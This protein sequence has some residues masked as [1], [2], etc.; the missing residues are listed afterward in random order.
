MRT[1]Y[2]K[3]LAMTL[4]LA[5]ALLC[6]LS[7]CD[8][9]EEDKT[10]TPVYYQKTFRN[11][12]DVEYNALDYIKVPIFSELKINKIEIDRKVEY[13]MANVV[14]SGAEYETFEEDGSA[15]VKLFDTANIT[16]AGKAKDESLDISDETMAGMDNSSNKEGSDLIIGSGSFIGEYFGDESKHNEGFEEQLIGMKV[17]ETKDI[18]VTFP[19]NYSTEELCGVEVIFTVKINSIDRAKAETLVPTD[20]ECET[21]TGGEYKT[22]EELKAYFEDTYK[23]QLAYEIIY[24]SI[25][26]TGQ[27]KEIVDIYI[28][29]YIHEYV[30]YSSEKGEQLTQKEY[31]SAYAEAY[32]S[33]Y[34]TAQKSAEA[35]ASDYIIS[36]Y[37][38]DYFEITLSDEEF[39]E[40]VQKIWNANKDYYQYYG[41]TSIDDLI[42]YFGRETMELSFKNEKLMKVIADSVTVVE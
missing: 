25:E 4:I 12:S 17:G 37:L 21:F 35:Q 3:I 1:A 8:R 6:A 13:A 33:M 10:E 42:N 11:V 19:D 32:N 15:E 29:K 36:N 38:F 31:D 16:F 41:M 39:N 34:D 9:S 22:A 7:G 28:D 40:S 2:L 30:I 5:S 14:L 26:V 27:C 23:A 24:T 18:T 20:K